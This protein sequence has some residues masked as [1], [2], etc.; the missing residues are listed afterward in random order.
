MTSS[1]IILI[2][3]PSTLN[4]ELTAMHSFTYNSKINKWWPHWEDFEC[5]AVHCY[6]AWWT[7]LKCHSSQVMPLTEEGR[8]FILTFFLLK[9]IFLD[10]LEIRNGNIIN[11]CFRRLTKY[12]SKYCKLIYQ[13][14]HRWTMKD[15]HLWLEGIFQITSHCFQVASFRPQKFRELIHFRPRL[16]LDDLDIWCVVLNAG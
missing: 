12:N 9:M 7:F 14:F 10:R 6:S 16:L 5:C 3:L 11:F 4:Y 15:R 13:L 2:F 8:W 1:S